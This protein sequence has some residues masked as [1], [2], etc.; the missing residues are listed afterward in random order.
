M[1]GP[2]GEP[3]CLEHRV[4]VGEHV[5]IP[6][7]QYT[8]TLRVQPERSLVILPPRCGLGVLPSIK[9]DDELPLVANEIHDEW[10]DRR[11]P[12]ELAAIELPEA[13]ALPEC[14]LGNRH[15]V[16]EFPGEVTRPHRVF[17]LPDPPHKGEGVD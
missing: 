10:A 12:S 16:S 6:K 14:F 15:L 13:Y 4:H 17:P 3:D 2:Q 11:L 9:L 7:P 5:V 1:G 8:K